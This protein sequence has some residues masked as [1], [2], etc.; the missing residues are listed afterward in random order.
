MMARRRRGLTICA[1]MSVKS[2]TFLDMPKQ[3]I[4]SFHLHSL[5]ILRGHAEMCKGGVSE[6]INPPLTT[7]SHSFKALSLVV[8]T[9]VSS[10]LRDSVSITQVTW[11]RCRLDT[12]K[13]CLPY[14][15][16]LSHQNSYSP[17]NIVGWFRRLRHPLQTS[18]PFYVTSRMGLK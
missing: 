5:Q 18:L 6:H 9:R 16:S 2:G 17:R 1:Y 4:W 15:L 13:I 12:I 14:R 11:W 3:P 8:L 10:S 7:A